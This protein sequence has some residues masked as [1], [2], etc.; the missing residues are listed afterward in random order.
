VTAGLRN[1]WWFRERDDDAVSVVSPRVSAS[2]RLTD[3]LVARGSV[4]RAFRAPTINERIRPFRA[5]N[6]LTLANPSLQPERL[7][8]A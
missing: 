3:H 2:F 5:G 8:L 6:V 4:G 1:D 7:T